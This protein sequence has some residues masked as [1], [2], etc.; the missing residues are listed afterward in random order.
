[1]VTLEFEP[2]PEFFQPRNADAQPI[3][4]FRVGY[5]LA[6]SDN[7]P[8]SLAPLRTVDFRLNAVKIT[9]Q[10]ARLSFTAGAMPAGKTKVVFRVRA[11]TA[12]GVSGEWSEPTT[13]MNLP[14]RTRATAAP[15]RSRSDYLATLAGYP[16]LVEDLR[17]VTQTAPGKDPLE[18]NVMWQAFPSVS[19]LAVAVVI[20]R[21]HGV[22]CPELARRMVGPKR[23]SLRAALRDWKD[24]K[25]IP[26]LIQSARA[27]AKL[28]T[29]SQRQ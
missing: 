1:V 4:K 22:P 15:R 6:P 20:C 26:A 21:D 19:D 23:Q 9:G 28:L 14:E 25:A 8:V 3:T 11:V 24:E 27:E 17:S 5:F 10:T 18:N 29:A 13:V 12:D 7:I 2:P 16:K